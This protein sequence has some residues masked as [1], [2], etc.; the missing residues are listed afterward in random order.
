MT[1][2]TILYIEDNAA[3][4][5]L[6]RRVLEAD[7]FSVIEAEDGLSGLEAARTSPPDLILLD[8]NLPEIDGYEMVAR[9]R[10]IGALERKLRSEPQL[11]RKVE[12]RRELKAKQAKLEQ[13]R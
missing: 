11:N 12:L 2:A 3:N 10:E 13:T 7:G 8:I 1:T 5:L 9:L 4:R 6:V